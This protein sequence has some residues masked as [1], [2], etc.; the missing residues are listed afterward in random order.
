MN[1]SISPI[2]SNVAFKATL[3]SNIRSGVMPQVIEEFAKITKN[4]KGT[5]EFGNAQYEP[6]SSGL[7]EF[8]YSGVSYVT[9]AANKYIEMPSDS[10]N[11]KEVK[12]VAQKFADVLTA[13]KIEESYVKKVDKLKDEILS[14]KEQLHFFDIKKKRAEY[15]GLEG[16]VEVYSKNIEKLSTTIKDKEVQLDSKGEV[17]YQAMCD[18]LSQYSE[19]ELLDSYVDFVKNSYI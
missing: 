19:H 3:K 9:R 17:W 18:K 12:S 11:V 2:N 6:I 16:L 10:L 1:N 5:L 7:K 13:L 8:V 14:L 15:H 4:V